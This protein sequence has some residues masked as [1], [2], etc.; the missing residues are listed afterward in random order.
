[1]FFF[2]LFGNKTVKEL[3]KN[4]GLTV[5]ELSDLAKINP[6]LIKRV[7]YLKF[8]QVPDPLKSKIEPFLKGKHIDKKPW[9]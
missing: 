4:Q 8:K 2:K 9:L 6:T 3:R 1:M 7:E 5:Q